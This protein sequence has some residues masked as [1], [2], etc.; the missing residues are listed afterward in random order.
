MLKIKP[1][2]FAGLFLGFRNL[3]DMRLIRPSML[4]ALAASAP[5]FRSPSSLLMAGSGVR[6]DADR[7]PAATA[8]ADQA[9]P[10]RE[11]KAPASK[12]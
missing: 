5:T 12:R 1:G 4:W 3:L 9:K 10:A 11:P 8:P 7:P 2:S 6:A